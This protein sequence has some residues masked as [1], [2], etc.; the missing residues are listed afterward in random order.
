[1]TCPKNP[2][3][4]RTVLES[5]VLSILSCNNR[6]KSV[7]GTL[8]CNPGVDC[9]LMEEG[10]IYSVVKQGNAGH[11]QTFFDIAGKTDGQVSNGLAISS[12]VPS[13]TD[14]AFVCGNCSSPC[15]DFSGNT[16][17][18]HGSQDS[19]VAYLKNDGTQV[20]FKTAGGTGD[21]SATALNAFGSG[22][23]SIHVIGSV[24]GGSIVD[25]AGNSVSAPGM[26]V[27]KLDSTGSQIYFK[28]AP[29]SNTT[30]G[31]ISAVV[32]AGV[33][34]VYVS[35]MMPVVSN[36]V[37]DFDG[38][39]VNLPS[40][41]SQI[42]FVAKFNDAGNQLFFKY[43]TQGSGIGQNMSV[44]SLKTVSSSAENVYIS[45]S[46][47]KLQPKG[48]STGF[49][50]FTGNNILGIGGQQ[51][52]FIIK[53]NSSGTQVFLKLAGGDLDTDSN[54][55]STDSLSVVTDGSNEYVYGSGFMSITN[56]PFVDFKGSTHSSVLGSLY[57][58][59][60]DGNGNQLYFRTA[61]CSSSP[62]SDLV[63][64]VAGVLVGTD[65]VVYLTGYVAGDAQVV[66]FNNSSVSVFDGQTA[67]VA[68]LDSTGTQ[69]FFKICGS[70]SNSVAF[71]L[72]SSIVCGADAG[73]YVLGNLQDVRSSVS[74]TDFEGN[75]LSFTGTNFR[76]EMFLSKL[77]QDGTQYFFYVTNGNSG[78]RIPNGLSVYTRGDH[79][80]AYVTGTLANAPYSFTDFKGNTQTSILSSG[81]DVFALRVDSINLPIGMVT[82]V[83]AT[84]GMTVAVSGCLDVSDFGLELLPG[85]I[86]YWDNENGLTDDPAN[87][88]WKMGI[89]I[90]GDMFLMQ[91]Q[92]E[93]IV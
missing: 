11:S 81:A 57:I 36:K 60:L 3:I 14:S 13:S 84:C 91:P 35:G 25:F 10:T 47:T 42:I 43:I 46:F 65:N 32:T 49:K 29:V 37:K 16:V 87:H 6:P 76:Q 2:S 12:I 19:F 41:T 92:L 59:K 48:G 90:D 5:E 39:V 56:F 82:P 74:V 24:A 50:D 52:A 73:V 63:L 80:G 58:V 34:S 31:Q 8:A 20:F 66:D 45:G 83:K 55:M 33:E 44:N 28:S 71:S 7:C 79:T 9:T 38:T 51:T 1:M 89:S 78:N 75:E 67:F 85:T 61:G 26:F 4:T 93:L 68:K 54:Y 86:Y 22:N 27:S 15:K 70:S 18:G 17:N 69:V 62:G 77:D 64:D 88:P 72:G 53:L 21:D 23:G 40:G 30:V